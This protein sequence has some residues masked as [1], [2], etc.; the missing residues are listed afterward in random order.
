MSPGIK[1]NCPCY[2]QIIGNSDLE[3]HLDN[4]VV[5]DDP[6]KQFLCL[7]LPWKTVRWYHDKDESTAQNFNF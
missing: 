6:R 4:V 7:L 3:D 1:L 2:S 5:Q